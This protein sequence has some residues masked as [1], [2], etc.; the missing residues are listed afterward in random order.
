[1][2][3]ENRDLEVK[4]ESKNRLTS[5]IGFIVILGIIL[6][7]A[8]MIGGYMYLSAQNSAINPDIN[9]GP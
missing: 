2:E 6:F 7:I 4:E 1:M 3:N 9:V 8:L 5:G